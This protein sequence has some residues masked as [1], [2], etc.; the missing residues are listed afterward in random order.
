MRL[1]RAGP[2]PA[3]GTPKGVQPTGPEAR[4]MDATVI[5]RYSMSQLRAL[6]RQEREWSRDA[7]SSLRTIDEW[8]SSLVSPCDADMANYIEAR[9]FYRE[10][11]ER[12][13]ANIAVIRKAISM[14]GGVK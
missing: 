10:S 3:S 11:L 14:K 4:R 6:E 2:R 13:Q 8:W 9:V 1:T 12:Y 5:V 7:V